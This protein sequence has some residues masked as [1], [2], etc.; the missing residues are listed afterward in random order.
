MCQAE[1]EFFVF[2]G[3]G[4]SPA[5]VFLVKSPLPTDQIP[6]PAKY[7]FRLEDQDKVAKV[8]GGFTLEL[9]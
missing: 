6:M 1:D 4:R 9:F 7:G 2:L 5:F 8:V 3:E